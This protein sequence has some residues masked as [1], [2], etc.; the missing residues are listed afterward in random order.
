MASGCGT[1]RNASGRRPPEALRRTSP[2]F[3][4]KL[5]TGMLPASDKAALKAA[6]PANAPR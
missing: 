6:L 1:R 3:N 4:V 2:R 5:P